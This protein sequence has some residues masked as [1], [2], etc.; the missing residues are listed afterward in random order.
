MKIML[1]LF[2]LL[3]I[4]II[5]G[6]I[7]VRYQQNIQIFQSPK[8]MIFVDAK[9]NSQDISALKIETQFQIPNN[10]LCVGTR[11]DDSRIRGIKINDK[12]VFPHYGEGPKWTLSSDKKY[13]IVND[14]KIPIKKAINTAHQCWATGDDPSVDMDQFNQ[15]LI[16]LSQI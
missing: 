10:T 9:S 14:I 1:S 15:Y 2:I 13:V 4:L 3:I 8:E 12:F 5:L 7:Y 6:C 16:Q 11:G